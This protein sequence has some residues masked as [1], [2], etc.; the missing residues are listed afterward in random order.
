MT[1]TITGYVPVDGLDVYYEI[2]GGPLAADPPFLLLHGGLGSIGVS[3]ADLAPRLAALRPV[4]AIEQQGH[5]HTA[6]RASP[7]SMDAMVADTAA[8]LRHLGVTSAH[9]V[10]HSMGAMLGFGLAVRHPD[11]AASLTAIAAT[12]T[13]DG[14]I[15]ELVTLQRDPTHEPSPE[16]LAI[17]PGEA[18]FAAWAA[19]FDRCNPKPGTFEQVSAKLNDMMSAWPGWDRNE[20]ARLDLPVLIAI[21]DRDF[22]RIDH[23][24]ETARMIPGAQLAILPGTT[25]DGTLQRGAW[26]V[27]MIEAGLRSQHL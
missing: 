25:H 24:S 27:P 12:Y 9:V 23:A 21:G 4:I 26:L 17:M 2:H 10:G 22:V 3:F 14:M 5:G 16:L 13:F 20:V 6:D 7:A 19:H 8:V 15:D 18:D 11:L 1:D